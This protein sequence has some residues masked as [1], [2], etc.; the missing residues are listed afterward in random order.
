MTSVILLPH[1][2]WF[3]LVMTAHSF[4]SFAASVQ[5]GTGVGDKDG[6]WH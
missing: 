1:N 4:A 5:R 6:H 3:P 2:M